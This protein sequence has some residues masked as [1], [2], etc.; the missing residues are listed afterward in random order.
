MQNIKENKKKMKI[1]KFV[2]EE[3]GLVLPGPIL[4]PLYKLNLF[5]HIFLFLIFSY[6][7]NLSLI[8][9]SCIKKHQKIFFLFALFPENVYLISEIK[10]II[11][12]CIFN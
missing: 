6:Y 1:V 8:F 5:F 3:K 9:L 2:K 11:F 10:N 12:A 4:F 7:F